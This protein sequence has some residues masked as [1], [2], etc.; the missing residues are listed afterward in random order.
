MDIF[1]SVP[2]DCQNIVFV[3]IAIVAVMVAYFVYNY[4]SKNGDGDKKKVSFKGGE[5]ESIETPTG[6]VMY[7]KDSCPWC[8]RQKSE[9]GDEWDKVTYVNCAESP[10]ACE[11]QKISAL[12]TWFINGNRT[13]GFMKKD[14]FV[15][16]CSN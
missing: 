1:K 8:K 14:T 9:L 12:P 6:I 16:K 11:E 13:E 4:K 7:G 3:L 2:S 5:N 15:K 10:G